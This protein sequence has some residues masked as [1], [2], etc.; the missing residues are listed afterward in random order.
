MRV[1]SVLSFAYN[2]FAIK[3]GLHSRGIDGSTEMLNSKHYYYQHR[4]N[5]YDCVTADRQR[6]MHT[7]VLFFRLL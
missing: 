7:S 2:S 5:I 1:D 3:V 6:L 4:M